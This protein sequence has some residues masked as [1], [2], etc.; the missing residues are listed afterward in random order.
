MQA[1]AFPGDAEI[2]RVENPAGTRHRSCLTPGELQQLGMFR[3]AY[4]VGE[5]SRA[6]LTITIHSADGMTVAV[7]D[8]LAQAVELAAQ[9]GLTLVA[10][11]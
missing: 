3:V 6:G 5:R 10:V 11:H 8:T 2:G 4:L 1:N 7:V 9:L